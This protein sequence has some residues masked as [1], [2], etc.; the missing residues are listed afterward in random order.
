MGGFIEQTRDRLLD[1]LE[2][3]VLCDQLLFNCEGDEPKANALCTRHCGMVLRVLSAFLERKSGPLLKDA[4]F[5]ELLR[6]NEDGNEQRARASMQPFMDEADCCAEELFVHRMQK[7]AKAANGE[8]PV[9]LLLGADMK[10]LMLFLGNVSPLLTICLMETFHVC[11]VNRFQG[12]GFAQ[13]GPI[14]IVQ[15]QSMVR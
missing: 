14:S 15:D 7:V 4:S 9:D 11:F 1:L 3:D 5:H 10:E 2:D 13:T 6:A 12:K 8:H